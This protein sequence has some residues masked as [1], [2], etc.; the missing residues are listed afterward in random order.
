M[1]RRKPIPRKRKTPRRNVVA[2]TDEGFREFVRR[3]RC[4]AC[5]DEALRQAT[6][7][8]MPSKSEA[9]HIKARRNNADAANLVPLCRRHH[10]EQH[11]T[12]ILS[13]QQK[14]FLDLQMLAAA[15]WER[16]QEEADQ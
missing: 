15:L 8:E 16:Y 11:T 5:S 12:G 14:Y 9:C 4:V 3:C 10:Q 6:P 2:N 13:F 1:K 7:P